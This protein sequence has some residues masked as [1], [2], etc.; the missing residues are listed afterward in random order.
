MEPLS[1]ASSVIAVVQIFTQTIRRPID[2]VDLYGVSG[3]FLYLFGSRTTWRTEAHVLGTVS[4]DDALN[5]KKSVQDECTMISVAAAIVAQIAITGLSL[6][7][8]SQTHWIVKASFVFSIISSLI[9]VYYASTQQRVMGRLLQAKQV[10]GW[11]RGRVPAQRGDSLWQIKRSH[12]FRGDPTDYITLA[13]S[14]GNLSPDIVEQC[15]TPS[16]ASVITMSAPQIL[17][18]ASLLSLLLALGM[19]FGF[20]WTRHLDV[21]AG[22]DGGGNV[23]I[24]YLITLTLCFAVYSV[25]RLIQDD[26]IRTERTIL[27]EYA[28]DFL[29]KYADVARVGNRTEGVA[30][31]ASD[32]PTS[33]A[34]NIA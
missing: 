17:L 25:S 21:D 5:F 10:R 8:L 6:D 3:I 31:E 4:D 27:L 23:L 1:L 19:Y 32:A 22:K 15:F 33:E 13:S 30:G 29:E 18:S 2:L 9:A 34:T 20:V 26:D 7:N 12:K 24:F 16:V 28:G 14:A 11:I